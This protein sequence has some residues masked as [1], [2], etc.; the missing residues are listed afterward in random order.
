[1][2]A[3]MQRFK[4]DGSCARMAQ[5]SY[6]NVPVPELNQQLDF[7]AKVYWNGDGDMTR[8]LYDQAVDIL[9]GSGR[10]TKAEMP[11]FEALVV[12]LPAK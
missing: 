5:Q 12:K 9:V 6:P 1:M 4:T 8:E 3:V 10:V 7:A 11:S 2:K